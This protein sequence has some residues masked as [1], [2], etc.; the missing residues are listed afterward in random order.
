MNLFHMAMKPNREAPMTGAFK[1]E[2]AF[3]S[4]GILEN[5]FE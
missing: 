5:V 1:R 4:L 3:I 2:Q